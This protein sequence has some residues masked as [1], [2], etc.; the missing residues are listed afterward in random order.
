MP[1][2]IKGEVDISLMVLRREKK[3]NE[4]ASLNLKD[5]IANSYCIERTVIK[6]LFTYANLIKV[7]P[8]P[9]LSRAGKR[10]GSKAFD[11]AWERS[12]LRSK[13]KL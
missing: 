12:S 2:L 3:F 10:G 4:A 6:G 5:T 8:F 1:P 11:E 13:I 9:P 7:F